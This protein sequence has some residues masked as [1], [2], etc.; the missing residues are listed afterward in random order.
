MFDPQKNCFDHVKQ[1]E[2][3]KKQAYIVAS[4]AAWFDISNHNVHKGTTVAELQRILHVTPEETMAFGDGLNDVELLE[5]AAYSFAMSNAFEQ[6]KEVA[7]FVT[8]S[9]DEDAVLH[10]IKKMIALQA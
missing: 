1:L 10:T 7:Q 2:K 4:E 5:R 6:I 3:F 8:K 9:N